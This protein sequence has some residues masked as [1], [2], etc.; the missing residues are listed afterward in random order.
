MS[1]LIQQWLRD[2][3]TRKERLELAKCH[4][5]E[6]LNQCEG[7]ASTLL[8]VRVRAATSLMQIQALRVGIFNLIAQH[9]HQQKAIEAIR[10]LDNLMTAPELGQAG[11]ASDVRIEQDER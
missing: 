10:L 3:I 8:R 5:T 2:G 9:H 7:D 4:L 11:H 6:C 1:Q